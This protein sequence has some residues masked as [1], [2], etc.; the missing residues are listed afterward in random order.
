MPIVVSIE[1]LTLNFE[2]VFD[3]QAWVFDGCDGVVVLFDDGL[4]VIVIRV[5]MFGE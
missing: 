1:L 2:I 4:D 3:G 5:I